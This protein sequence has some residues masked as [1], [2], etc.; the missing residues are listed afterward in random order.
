MHFLIVDGYAKAS[1]DTF[2]KVGM[3][4]AWELFEDML[5]RY[6]PEATTQVWLPSD[7][8]AMPTDHELTNYAGLLWTGC[9]LTIYHQGNPAIDAMIDLQRRAYE[10]GLEAFGSCWG[11]QMAVYSL[12]GRVEPNA[13]GREMGVGRKI[14]LTEAGQEHP[15]YRS[16]PLVFDAFESHEDIV[17][18]VPL[19]TTVL[20][21]NAFS[22]IQSLVVEHK[23]TQFWATQYHT[24]YDL[25][26][27]AMLTLARRERLTD[28]GF[29]AALDD[30]DELADKMAALAKE[31][32][33]KDLQWQ[34]GI[35]SDLLD[36]GV[37]QTEFINWLNQRVFSL[38]GLDPIERS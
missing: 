27:V 16:K 37:R 34:L 9:N 28:Q 22:G 10:H 24:E 33:R 14:R 36:D 23:G 13:R 6:L 38:R 17:T 32:H 1:R 3:K 29:F 31:P 20:A 11:M 25:H 7:G 21:V 12:G 8:E 26:E 5:K 19:G 15:M 30:V 4:L 35:D 2:R 18:E